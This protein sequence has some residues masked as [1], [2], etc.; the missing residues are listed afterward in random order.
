MFI[1]ISEYIKYRI[2]NILNWVTIFITFTLDLIQY[3]ENVFKER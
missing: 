3:L 1:N 2:L